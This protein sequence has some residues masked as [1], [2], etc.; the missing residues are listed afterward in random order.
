MN[1][2]R[3]N[4]GSVMGKEVLDLSSG[5]FLGRAQSITVHALEKRVVGVMLKQKGL[6]GGKN[7]IPLANIKAFGSH[8]MC[9]RDRPRLAR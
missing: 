2:Q 7:I 8:K 9:I 1:D 5:S 4:V 3:V 6:L